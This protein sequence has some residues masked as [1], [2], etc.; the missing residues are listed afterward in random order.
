MIIMI[1]ISACAL[2][3]YVHT[4]FV[5]GEQSV[6][7]VIKNHINHAEQSL[8]KSRKA[9]KNFS[10]ISVRIF[11]YQ[12]SPKITF[13]MMFTSSPS[14][15]KILL[16]IKQR[17]MNIRNHIYIY[18]YIYIYIHICIY[19]YMF[20]CMYIFMYSHMKIYVCICVYIHYVYIHI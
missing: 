15:N 10:T 7:I 3:L 11:L 8:S 5:F 17:F 20:I 14:V 2:I 1:A 18:I 16:Y 19:V 13:E 12:K 6:Q 4:D 9:T